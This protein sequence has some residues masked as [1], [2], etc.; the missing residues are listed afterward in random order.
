MSYKRILLYSLLIG[1]LNGLSFAVSSNGNI[2]FRILQSF[3]VQMMMFI[4]ILL[5]SLFF[6]GIIYAFFGDRPLTKLVVWFIPVSIL[7]PPA[8]NFSFH[9]GQIFILIFCWI[10]ILMGLRLLRIP[11][12]S[13]S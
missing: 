13:G 9:R 11:R 1:L 4:G 6:S 2:D 7:L 12:K 3:L 10:G 5:Y 8:V